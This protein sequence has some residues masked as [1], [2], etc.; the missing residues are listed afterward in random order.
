MHRTV[1]RTCALIV[2]LLV[3]SSGRQPAQRHAS[4]RLE[5]PH[6]PDRPVRTTPPLPVLLSGPIV[7]NFGLGDCRVRRLFLESS[8]HNMK[9][10]PCLARMAACVPAVRGDLS[11][12]FFGNRERSTHRAACRGARLSTKL[13]WDLQQRP[14]AC[15]VEVY[16]TSSLHA[17]LRLNSA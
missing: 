3:Q 17:E 7:Q 13:N 6:K 2:L 1:C 11:C 15:L 8:S 9:C 4:R 12:S 5:C 10:N 14:L 16:Q